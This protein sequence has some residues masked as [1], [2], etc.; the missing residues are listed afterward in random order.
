MLGD[1][2]WENLIYV[3]TVHFDM[4]ADNESERKIK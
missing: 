3:N 2:F 4:R 1:V